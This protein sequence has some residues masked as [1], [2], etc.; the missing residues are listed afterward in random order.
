MRDVLIARTCVAHPAGCE[1]LYELLSVLAVVHL[2]GSV[3]DDE[4]LGTVID[5]PDIRWSSNGADRSEVLA[6]VT[7]AASGVGTPSQR[8]ISRY[9][10]RS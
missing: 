6:E 4:D 3:E 10:L 2:Y 7:S 8:K 9:A 1:R 5:V